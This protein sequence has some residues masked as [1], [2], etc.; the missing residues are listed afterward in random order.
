LPNIDLQIEELTSET[1]MMFASGWRRVILGPVLPKNGPDPQSWKEAAL[2][3]RHDLGKYIRLSAPA[4][5]EADTEALRRRLRDDVL[6]TRSDGAG[7]RGAVEIFDAWK[8]EERSVLPSSGPAA[9]RLD[10]IAMKIEMV[11]ALAPRL[12]RLGREELV[13]LDLLTRQIAHGCRDLCRAAD[14]D[15]GGR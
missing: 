6:A 15:E 9:R 2:R 10:R 5:R 12:D 14:S 1:E 4:R 11:R 7:A 13:Q 3:L 8:K